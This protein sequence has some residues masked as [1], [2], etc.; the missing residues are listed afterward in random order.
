M[1]SKPSLLLVFSLAFACFI[2]APAFLGRPFPAYPLMHWADVFDIL[3]PL[4]LIPLYWLL[5]TDAGRRARSRTLVITF[6]VLGALWTEGQGMHLSAN[7]IGNLQGGGSTDVHGLVD[8]YDE[9]LSHYLWHIGIVGLSVLLLIG[10]TEGGAA[11]APIRWSLVIP[12]SFLYGFTYFA[13]IDEGTTVPFGLPAAILIVLGLWLTR[14]KG[15]RS[16]N[17]TAFIFL[18][19]VL[20]L[21]LFAGWFA[22]WGWFPEFSETGFI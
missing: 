8:F 9:V 11:P 15:L 2:L 7:S 18:A 1:I 10:R 16:E 17:L 14:R 6:L 22:Y 4:V 19:Y 5:F 21:L 20:A 12:S 3:T 13:A